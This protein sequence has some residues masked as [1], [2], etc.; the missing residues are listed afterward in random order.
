MIRS[1]FWSQEFVSKTARADRSDLLVLKEM[2]ETG[3]VKPVIDRRFSL[4]EAVSALA[5]QSEGHARGKSVV[6]P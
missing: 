3:Q 1:R 4:D 6:I 5:Y 2:V